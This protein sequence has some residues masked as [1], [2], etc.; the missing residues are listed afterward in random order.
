MYMCVF[1]RVYVYVHIQRIC[2][3]NLACLNV[4][5]PITHTHTHTNTRTK[6]TH[7]KNTRPPHQY[8]H[9][10]VRAPKMGVSEP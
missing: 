9:A 10:T 6:H 2:A 1:V 8:V 7:N 4:A 3:P 5:V